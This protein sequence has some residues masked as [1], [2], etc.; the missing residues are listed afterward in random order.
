MN[1]ARSIAVNGPGLS[2]IS[3]LDFCHAS[4]FGLVIA[5]AAPRNMPAPNKGILLLQI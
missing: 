4:F 1:G 5:A 2:K 3:Y